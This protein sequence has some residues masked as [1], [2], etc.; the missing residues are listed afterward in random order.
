MSRA[1]QV[2]ARLAELSG[3]SASEV[4]AALNEF[5]AKDIA[6][7]VASS[8]GG[9][10][11]QPFRVVTLD[12]A[13]NTPGLV[14][15]ESGPAGVKICDLAEFEALLNAGPDVLMNL[16]VFA[17]W[18][19]TDPTLQLTTTAGRGDLPG[20]PPA[21]FTKMYTLDN[22]DVDDTGTGAF[23]SALNLQFDALFY[24]TPATSLYAYIDDGSGGDPAS[25]EGAGQI[26]IVVMAAP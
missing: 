26:V 12:I 25:T 8:G 2:V 23:T 22:P 13:F 24:F 17:A 19:G 15:P 20:T 14:I 4:R 3:A 16:R 11:S 6:A 9:G 7:A 18:D 10:G 21:P 1:D 5:D